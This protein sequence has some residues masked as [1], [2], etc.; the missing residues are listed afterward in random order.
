MSTYLH[1]VMFDIDGT[2]VQ[3]SDLDDDCF[4]RAIEEILGIVIDEVWSNYEHVTDKGILNEIIQSK[5]LN[6]QKDEIHEKV[7][8]T[9]VR[10][11]RECLEKA[12]AQEVPGASLFLT[13]LSAM[14]NVV[15]SIATGGWYESAV[16][17]L[18]SAGISVTN[19]PIASSNDHF[20]RTEIMKIAEAEA[21]NSAAISNT[22]FGDG[23]WD[24]KAC[25]ELGY[26]FVLVGN[27]VKHDQNIENFN[28][29]NEAMAYIGL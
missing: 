5:G 28:S 18:K 20:S 15:I 3:S 25:E 2:L 27:R 24:K 7:K 11:I 22:Y 14:N 6:D 8:N 29:A 21:T 26:N 4:I 17:K 9:F 12:P 13:R 1:H 19:I 23:P 16:L 10:K